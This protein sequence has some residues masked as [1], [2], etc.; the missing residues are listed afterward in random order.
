MSECI[1]VSPIYLERAWGGRKLETVFGRQLPSGHLFGEAWELVDRPDA[2]SIVNAGRYAGKALHELWQ[3]GRE[4]L[5][6][7]DY[8]QPRFPLLIKILDASEALS[9]QVHPPETCAAELSGEPKTE[10]WYFVHTEPGAAVYAG[11]RRAC[12]RSAF[13]KALRQGLVADQVHRIPSAADAFVL[14]PSG[15]LHA[16]GAGNVIF[17][18]QQNSDTTYRV[19]DW[20]RTGPDGKRRTLHVQES[21]RCIDF[22]DWEPGLGQANGETLV[23]CPHFFVDRW[24]LTK[25]RPANEMERFSVFQVVRG[26]VSCSGRVFGAGDLFLVPANQAATKITPETENAT[27]LRT[28]MPAG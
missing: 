26:S 6:G 20:E 1:T 7:P 17:E 5:F 15:R 2:Q 13:E 8:R 14:I 21:L 4:A 22:S 24:H 3:T 9:V 23:A 10:M 12:D 25:D 11:L 27:L 16:I 18:I 19:F 28:T